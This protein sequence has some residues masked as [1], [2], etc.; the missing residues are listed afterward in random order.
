MYVFRQRQITSI[1]VDPW[2]MVWYRIN[3]IEKRLGEVVGGRLVLKHPKF[4]VLESNGIDVGYY[5]TGPRLGAALICDHQNSF[6]GLSRKKVTVL[7]D[8]FTKKVIQPIQRPLPNEES[9]LPEAY[10]KRVL[11]ELTS[12]GTPPGLTGSPTKPRNMGLS[13]P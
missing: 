12:A 2:L 4:G 7:V 5:G 11:A 1:S 3:G 13:G 6:E 8:Q 10:V 9:Q